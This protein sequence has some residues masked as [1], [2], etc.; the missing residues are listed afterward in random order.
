VDIPCFIAS[1]AIKRYIL[2]VYVL[3]CQ[4]TLTL[5]L[6]EAWVK[7]EPQDLIGFSSWD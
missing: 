3:V 1:L 7:L 6:I 4:G 2:Y 5:Q